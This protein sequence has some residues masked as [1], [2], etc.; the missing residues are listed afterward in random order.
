MQENAI[1]TASNSVH[2]RNRRASNPSVT[3]A[4]TRRAGKVRF[5]AAFRDHWHGRRGN[6]S[7]Q[8][9]DRPTTARRP[10]LKR[11]RTAVALGVTAIGLTGASEL[12]LSTGAFAGNLFA[13]QSQSEPG[14]A[15]DRTHAARLAVSDDMLH[16]MIDEEGVRFEVYRDVAGYPTVGV[17]HRIVPGDGLQIGNTISRDRAMAFLQHDLKRAEKG[18]RKLVG[19]LPITQ[20]EFD[21]L[22]D[23]VFNVG[24]GTVSERESPRL[25]EAIAARD[26]D[27]IAQELE[28]TRAK[29]IVAK[30]LAFRSERRTE[31]FMN[32]DYSDPRNS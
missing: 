26:Y 14:N 22:V 18:V 8:H 15:T 27:G 5:V 24:A 6:A 31:I 32:A 11:R 23:L 16:A 21:A 4:S 17:G 30:G 29:N 28:Y 20:H 10:G 2:T 13:D 19:D 9:T 1:Q 7:R 12:A 3:L 25:N